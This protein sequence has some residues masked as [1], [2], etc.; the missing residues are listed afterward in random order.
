MSEDNTKKLKW[1]VSYRL[2]NVDDAPTEFDASGKIVPSETTY[3]SEYVAVVE[4]NDEA[5]ARLACEAEHS[6]AVIT[7]IRVV[8]NG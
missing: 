3:T 7:G 8:G 5:G 1:K 4:A 6:G 2:Q